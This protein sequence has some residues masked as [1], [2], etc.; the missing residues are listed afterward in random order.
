M[1]AVVAAFNQEKAL[2]GAF[3]VITNLRMQ[4]F[5][6]RLSARLQITSAII[7][8]CGRGLAGPGLVSPQIRDCS[9]ICS[10]PHLNLA[11]PSV[12]KWTLP[13]YLHCILANPR[14]IP[15]F[16][17]HFFLSSSS[18]QCGHKWHEG[19]TRVRRGPWDTGH[20]TIGANDASIIG[21]L[22][23]LFSTI[24]TCFE[25]IKLCLVFPW[26]PFWCQMLGRNILFSISML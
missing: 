26:K 21:A 4:R 11:T 20:Q 7:G 2:V 17:G 6:E 13:V 22:C 1:K 14:F 5:E 18:H 19:R 3:S 25:S 16:W 8:C 12:W 23:V 24:A 10:H 15:T 9:V